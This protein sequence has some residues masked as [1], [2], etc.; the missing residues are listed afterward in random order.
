MGLLNFAYTSNDLVIENPRFLKKSLKKLRKVQKAH[1]RAKRGGQNKKKLTRKISKVHLK[2]KNQR[3]DFLHKTTTM[4]VKNH[5][6]IVV[7]SLSIKNMIRNRHLSRSISDAAWGIFVNL[8][9][10]K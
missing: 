3:N 8:L 10:Y 1:S 4:L 2:I 9:K 7:E 6:A 5:D